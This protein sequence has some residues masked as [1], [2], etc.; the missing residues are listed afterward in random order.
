MEP[1]RINRLICNYFGRHCGVTYLCIGQVEIQYT[2][3]DAYQYKNFHYTDKIPKPVKIPFISKQDPDPVY[4][5]NAFD[6]II[7]IQ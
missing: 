1:S 3:K 2:Y 4:F 7:S 6:G 5:S